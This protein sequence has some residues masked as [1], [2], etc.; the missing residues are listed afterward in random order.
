MSAWSLR[1]IQ[2]RPCN[3]FNGDRLRT[4]IPGFSGAFKR[5]LA[6]FATNGCFS[7]GCLEASRG[8]RFGCGFSLRKFLN[9]SERDFK[10]KGVQE[11]CSFHCELFYSFFYSS[12]SSSICSSIWPA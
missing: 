5:L 7:R 9:Q 8:F 11:G 1:G 4:L 3:A 12:L 10:N 2:E 6:Q